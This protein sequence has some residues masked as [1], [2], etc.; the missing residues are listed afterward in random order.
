M[1][2]VRFNYLHIVDFRVFPSSGH[3]FRRFYEAL[4]T[5]ALLVTKQQTKFATTYWAVTDPHICHGAW[6][7]ALFSV[8]NYLR[9]CLIPWVVS[10]SLII[11][12]CINSPTLPSVPSVNSVCWAPYLISSLYSH[13]G[14]YFGL[15]Q[16]ASSQIKQLT[17][18][19][20]SAS[21]MWVLTLA[22]P[23]TIFSIWVGVT[24]DRYLSLSDEYQSWACKK[25]ARC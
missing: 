18:G 15:Y 10:T 4:H 16:S 19:F 20:K 24:R 5:S 2:F 1:H 25:A 17:F 22:F 3:G 7:R 11:T 21:C 12:L 14:F 8:S 6:F 9:L 13:F 23:H